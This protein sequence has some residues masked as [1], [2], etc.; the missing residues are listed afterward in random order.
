MCSIELITQNDR[1]KKY[2]ILKKDGSPL[3]EFFKVKI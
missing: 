3:Q 1:K 2:K